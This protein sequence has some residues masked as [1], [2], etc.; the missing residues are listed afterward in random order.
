MGVPHRSATSPLLTGEQWRIEG[1]FV[2]WREWRYRGTGTCT[3]SILITRFAEPHS[4]YF[5]VFIYSQNVSMLFPMSCSNRFQNPTRYPPKASPNTSPFA[6]QYGWNNCSLCMLCSP[7]QSR[8]R[9]PKRRSIEIADLEQGLTAGMNH[10]VR[11]SLVHMWC[12][13][14]VTDLVGISI[15]NI[16]CFMSVFKLR[17]LHRIYK[18][19]DLLLLRCRHFIKWNYD[20]S[21]FLSEK[22]I[23]ISAY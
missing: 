14:T 20:E 19:A 12:K 9:Y 18:I 17:C 13:Q 7:P 10:S 6:P 5:V 3:S 8:T 15:Q 4:T 11:T 1:G 16:C 22:N 21:S 2:Q 23:Y